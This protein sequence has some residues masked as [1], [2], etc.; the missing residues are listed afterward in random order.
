MYFKRR[1]NSVSPSPVSSLLISLS[2]WWARGGTLGKRLHQAPRLNSCQAPGPPGRRACAQ[3]PSRFVRFCF[4]GSLP[5]GAPRSSRRGTAVTQA[6]HD[7]PELINCGK[8]RVT[9]HFCASRYGDSSQ[10]KENGIP[11]GTCW[12]RMRPSW[13]HLHIPAAW[14]GVVV[15]SRGLSENAVSSFVN[16][17]R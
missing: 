9:F 17:H 3:P 8:S 2:I 5:D 1:E 15:R 6:V 14:L 12:P 16:T 10:R 11:V 13:V 7:R 4:W